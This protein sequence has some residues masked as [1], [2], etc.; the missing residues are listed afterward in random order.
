MTSSHTSLEQPCLGL[1]ICTDMAAQGEPN[2][3]H[4]PIQPLQA[5]LCHFSA[6]RG[7]YIKCK[8]ALVPDIEPTYELSLP[9]VKRKN[10]NST[11]HATPR[12]AT[13]RRPSPS[14]DNSLS[15]YNSL[16]REPSTFHGDLS[17]AITGCLL[18][19]VSETI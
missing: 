18:C 3:P 7:C 14:A 16:A 12:H 8:R 15:E 17:V 1:G 10:K 2:Y 13:P 11:R 9:N 6:C 5:H 4:P 19:S